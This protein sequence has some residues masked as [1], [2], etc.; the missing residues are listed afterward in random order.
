MGDSYDKILEKRD[1]T[2]ALTLS[3]D[4]TFSLIF[5]EKMAIIVLTKSKT[6][7]KWHFTIKKG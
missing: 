1:K 2:D 7:Q 5:T 4:K 6:S 3:H